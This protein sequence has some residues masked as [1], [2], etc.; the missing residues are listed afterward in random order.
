MYWLTL[1]RICETIDN[2]IPRE[3]SKILKTPRAVFGNVEKSKSD[4]RFISES[5]RLEWILNVAALLK[6]AYLSA[7]NLLFLLLIINTKKS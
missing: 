6:S 5:K 1:R 7:L 2:N 3:S 4:F